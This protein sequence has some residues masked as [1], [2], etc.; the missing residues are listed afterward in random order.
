MKNIY[1]EINYYKNK[2]IQTIYA[3]T[4]FWNKL[5]DKNY[6]A[7]KDGNLRSFRS[8]KGGFSGFVPFHSEIR[9]SKIKKNDFNKINKLINSFKILTKAKKKF[10]V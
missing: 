5:I 9:R 3:P 4:F 1:H 10:L 7:I 8:Q 2:K 6:K